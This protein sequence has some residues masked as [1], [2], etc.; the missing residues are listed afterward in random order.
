MTNQSY[1]NK[2]FAF[3]IGTNSIGWAVLQLNDDREPVH[4][5]DAGARIFSDGREAQ[6]GEPL[7]VKRRAR[8]RVCA[9]VTSAVG[10]GLYQN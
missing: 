8:H 6:T 5:V 7:A 10:R 9:I 2:L 4:I 3:D 1:S